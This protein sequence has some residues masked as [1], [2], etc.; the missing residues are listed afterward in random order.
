[1]KYLTMREG[2]ESVGLEGLHDERQ[3]RE[4][5]ELKMGGREKI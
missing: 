2:E 3:R 5:G 4:K 1:M